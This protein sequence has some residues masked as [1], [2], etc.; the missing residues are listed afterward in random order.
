MYNDYSQNS[1]RLQSSNTLLRIK[2]DTH[3]AAGSSAE[4]TI[5]LWYDGSIYRTN[6]YPTD[7][8][9]TY[10]Y[11]L[12]Q[13]EILGTYCDESTKLLV[14][15]SGSTDA[16]AF[17]EFSIVDNANTYGITSICVE[18]SDSVGG[19]YVAFELP[20]ANCG[21][22]YIHYS[23]LCIDNYGGSGGCEPGKQLIYFDT[24]QPNIFITHGAWENA[25]QIIIESEECC[26]NL[27]SVQK[28]Y[29]FGRFA[30]LEMQNDMFYGD[31]NHI[32]YCYYGTQLASI[33]NEEEKNLVISRMQSNNTDDLK[34]G[35]R[36]K[37]NEW[38]WE[39]GS[40]LDYTFW[41]QEYVEPD[42]DDDIGVIDQPIYE[43]LGRKEHEDYAW[44][45]CNRYSVSTPNPTKV[46]TPNP[47]TLAPTLP[48]T[49]PGPTPPPTYNTYNL[50]VGK[51]KRFP[52]T[53]D[54]FNIIGLDNDN[55][56]FYNI[57]KILQFVFK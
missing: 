35:L 47:T 53:I 38:G 46:L 3:G 26:D 2:T 27:E 1:R 52:L 54:P 6:I 10:E 13:M 5:T 24:N 43:M 8:N 16:A 19:G 36:V 4:I 40:P 45:L 18:D 33:L 48:P 15:N 29:E 12:S 56:V 28:Q 21:T 22:G 7:I 32:C 37:D 14:D 50:L 9:T 49:T 25:D 34:T 17:S 20:D 30:M 42:L 51:D 55:I 23:G 39:D 44:I 11:D 31:A 57:L 41:N